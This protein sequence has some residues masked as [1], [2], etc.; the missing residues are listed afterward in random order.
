MEIYNIKIYPV[1]KRDLREII[2]YLNT[3]SPDAAIRYYDLIISK[4]SSLTTMPYRC[5]QVRNSVLKS[6]GYRFLVVDNYIV[7]FVVQDETVQIRR[8]LYNKQNYE[9]L[10]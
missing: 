10:L 9:N 5:P 3:L 7:F 8:I 6:K 4:I 2:D 1:A